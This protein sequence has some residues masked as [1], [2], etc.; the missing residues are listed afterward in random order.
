MNHTFLYWQATCLVGIDHCY[1]RLL[2][3]R[4]GGSPARSP[5]FAGHMSISKSSNYIGP[6]AWLNTF[7]RSRVGV[8]TALPWVK[9]N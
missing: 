4:G 5:K 2:P 6:A 3:L 7:C 9:Y 1:Y 8:G